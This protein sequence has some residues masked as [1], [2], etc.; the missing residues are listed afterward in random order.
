[1]PQYQ[2]SLRID[3]ELQMEKEKATKYWTE[4]WKRIVAVVKFL[5]ERGLPFRGSDE[6]LNSRN[7]G[8]FLGSIDLC[9]S[10]IFSLRNL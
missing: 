9:L 8:N 10:F 2:K 3:T 4:I 1:M 5:A 6:L 7:S